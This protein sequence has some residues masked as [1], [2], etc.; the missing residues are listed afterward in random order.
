MKKIWIIGVLLFCFAQ[1]QAQD[2]LMAQKPD[3]KRLK[4]LLYTSGALYIGSMSFLYTAW[5]KGYKQAPFHWADDAG[6]WLQKDKFGHLTTAYEVGNYGYWALRWAGVSEKKAVWWGGTSGLM[7]LTT[8]EFFDGLSA[9]WGASPTDLL[10]NTLGSALFISQQLVWHDQRIRLKF[11]YHPTMYAQYN[12]S[13][14][15]DNFYQRIIKDYNGETNWLSINIHSFLKQD[16]RFPA[17]LNVAVGYGAKGMT[18]AY[19]DPS[20]VNGQPIPEFPRVRQYYLSVDVDWTKIK[21]NSHFLRFMFKVI[22]FVKV[23]APAIEYNREDGWRV[24]ALF[25]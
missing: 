4:T 6:E 25:F 18:G 2:T 9:E 3:K 8:V 22:S 17:W 11:S 24:H 13:V 16:S 10:A 5:Y 12:P 23:P 14:L 20:S 21:T 1:A 15:G 7:F 19:G